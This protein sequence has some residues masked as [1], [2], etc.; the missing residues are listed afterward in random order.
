MSLDKESS[1]RLQSLRFPLIVG[2]VYIHAYGTS[3]AYGSSSII[4]SSPTPIT[5]FTGLLISQGVA[6]L[7]VPLYFLMCGYFFLLVTTPRYPLILRSFN[8]E[9]VP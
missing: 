2:V 3:V 1:I 8:Q 4:V 6:R 9:S 5:E 7:S